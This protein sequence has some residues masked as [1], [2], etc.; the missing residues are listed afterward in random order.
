MTTAKD[1]IRDFAKEIVEVTLEGVT[2]ENGKNTEAVNRLIDERLE[3]KLD[4]LMQQIA[5][6]ICG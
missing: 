6:K 2:L 4:E 1:L 5:D 3:E